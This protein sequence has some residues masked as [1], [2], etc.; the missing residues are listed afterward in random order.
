LS[1]KRK[2]VSKEMDRKLVREITDYIQEIS[3]KY[4]VYAAI[5]HLR[6]IRNVARKGNF[7]GVAYRGMIHRWSFARIRNLLML[8]LKTIGFDSKR[9]LAVPEQWTSIK[10]HKCGHRGMRPK[11]NLFICHTCG[12]RTNADLNG[13]INIGRRL[14]MLIPSLRDE[15]GLGM[16]LLPREKLTPKAQRSTRSK[17]KSVVDCDDQTILESFV[18]SE[19][20]AMAK[21]VETSTVFARAGTCDEPMQRS[22]AGSRQRNYVF[23]KSGKAHANEDALRHQ[24]SGDSSREKGGT[25]KF[26]E[27]ALTSLERS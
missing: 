16:W 27:S 24:H 9:F 5:G 21:T 20:P 2:R 26:L 13:A 3:L 15:K 4:E 12:Y 8:K 14:I 18:N 25:Q 22:E 23:V 10:C 1:G 7:R 17:G 19:D 6:G 11:Q